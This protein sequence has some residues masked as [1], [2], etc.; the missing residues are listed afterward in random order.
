[1]V[2]KGVTY[3]FQLV[4]HHIARQKFPQEAKRFLLRHCATILPGSAILTLKR[5]HL[6]MRRKNNYLKTFF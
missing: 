4:C 6:Q 5:D 2:D 1:M 3:C